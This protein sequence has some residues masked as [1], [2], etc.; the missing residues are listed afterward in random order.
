MTANI[1]LQIAIYGYDFKKAAKEC[2]AL[3]K[4]VGLMPLLNNILVSAV[5]WMGART[6]SP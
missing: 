2:W 6:T 3:V 4:D 5:G 1:W